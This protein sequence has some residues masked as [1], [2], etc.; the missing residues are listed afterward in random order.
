MPHRGNVHE[1]DLRPYFESSRIDF[2]D[3]SDKR[4]NA[5]LQ[6][7]HPRLLPLYRISSDRIIRF[8]VIKPGRFIESGSRQSPATV[9]P[10]GVT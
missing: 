5:M 8:I 1:R 4:A 10:R 3:V 2:C 6:S 9:I 7:Q